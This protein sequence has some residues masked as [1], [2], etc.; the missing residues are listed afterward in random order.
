MTTQ[1]ILQ[2]MLTAVSIIAVIV[3]IERA[4]S[5]VYREKAADAAAERAEESAREANEHRRAASKTWERIATLMEIEHLREEGRDSERRAQAAEE[6]QRRLRA[7][8]GE[9]RFLVDRSNEHVQQFFVHWN[10][11]PLTI[12]GLEFSLYDS[13]TGDVPKQWRPQLQG[14]REARWP[15][16][17]GAD[18][19]FNHEAMR[20][21]MRFRW[22]AE[23]WR[24][25]I[26][27]TDP[28]PV[29]SK[30]DGRVG[31]LVRESEE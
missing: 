2:T 10:G 28:I 21:V 9:F 15:W 18:F 17:Q 4:R 24:R 30:A 22:D 7:D 11:C 16:K 23:R 5:A 6:E 13:R 31:P 27:F 19:D 1:E 3:T 14:R 25:E 29:R 26:T 8:F 12:D 20:V